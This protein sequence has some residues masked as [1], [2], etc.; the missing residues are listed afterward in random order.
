MRSRRLRAHPWPI[1]VLAQGAD[2]VKTLAIAGEMLVHGEF[3]LF[4]LRQYGSLKRLISQ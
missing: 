4:K 3:T 1:R 2:L